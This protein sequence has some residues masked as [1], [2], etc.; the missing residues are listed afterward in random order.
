MSSVY[1][2]REQMREENIPIRSEDMDF[3]MVC[4]DMNM[5]DRVWDSERK[6]VDML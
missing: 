5:N 6:R 4:F 1:I 3:L 2:E